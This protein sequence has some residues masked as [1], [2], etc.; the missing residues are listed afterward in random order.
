MVQNGISEHDVTANPSLLKVQ[1]DRQW[2]ECLL[3]YIDT[4]VH[5]RTEC[6]L[7]SVPLASSIAS[8]SKTC[9]VSCCTLIWLAAVACFLRWK[10]L[11]AG[12]RKLN[13]CPK[14]L[15]FAHR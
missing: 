14:L 4:S 5:T 15:R 3:I 8:S 7:S 1:S 11:T 9:L 6:Q 12:P 10:D 2:E 13:K